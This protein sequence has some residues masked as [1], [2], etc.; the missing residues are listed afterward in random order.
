MSKTSSYHTWT[1]YFLTYQCRWTVAVYDGD[2]PKCHAVSRERLDVECCVTHLSL[3]RVGMR[4][5][6]Q[7]LMAVSSQPCP[8]WTLLVKRHS[9]ATCSVTESCCVHINYSTSKN[10]VVAAWRPTK[11]TI[12]SVAQNSLASLVFVMFFSNLSS[13]TCGAF[14][15][16]IPMC[17]PFKIA[18]L[19]IRSVRDKLQKFIF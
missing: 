5:H 13:V 15:T 11:D 10:N 19:R 9:I 8:W 7:T 12:I 2:I 1:R 14:V 16:C 4:S 6:T 17:I 18:A 3:S